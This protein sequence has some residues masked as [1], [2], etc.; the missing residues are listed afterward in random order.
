ME[1]TYIHI[2]HIKFVK[3]IDL[4]KHTDEA[5]DHIPYHHNAYTQPAA[6]D[7]AGCVYALN[8]P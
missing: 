8:D 7:S 2:C 1:S 6:H 3:S 5:I 4:P